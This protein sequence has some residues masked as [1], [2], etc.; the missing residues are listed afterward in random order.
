MAGAGAAG[1]LFHKD[2]A[3][4]P[5]QPQSA[6]PAETRGRARISIRVDFRR[7]ADPARCDELSAF[8]R[9]YRDVI[10]EIAF[11]T[12]FTHP[13]CPLADIQSRAAVLAG[14]LPRF[15]DLGLSAGINHIAMIG[16]LEENL[17]HSLGEP[18]QHLVDFD[19]TVSAACYCTADP[20]MRDYVRSCFTALAKAKP[21]FIW[22]DDDVRLEA[23]GRIRFACFCDRCLAAFSAQ[24]GKPWRRETLVAALQSGARVERLALRR[25]WL[26]HNRAYIKELMATVREAVD[27][28]DPAISLGLMTGETA[29]SG[30]GS[31]D[32]APVLAGE[33][34]RPVK[35]RP[36]GGFYNDDTPIQLLGKAHAV[37]RQIA[38]VP[39]SVGDIQY[40]LENF[41]YQRLKKSAAIFTTEIATAIAAGCTGAAL[42]C[43]GL[44][45]EPVAE[46]QAYFDGV[47]ARRAFYDKAVAAF[48]RSPSEGIWTAFT[49][50]HFATFQADGDWFA[51]PKVRGSDLQYINE[52][53]EIGLPLAY[54]RQGSRL[55][56]LSGDGCLDFTKAEL[57]ELLSRGLLLD[58][59]ALARLYELGLGE[60]AGFAVR[61]MKE[62]DT[63]E[64]FTDDVL[65]GRFAGR[66]R[67]CRPSFYPEPAWLIEP[68]SPA[69]RVLAEI[70]D[71]APASFGPTSGVF[72]NRLG[73]R[74]AVF[75][76]YPWRSLQS[77]AKTSQLKAVCRWLS[78]DTLPACVTSYAK[79]AV[80]CRRDPRGRQA[81]LLLNASLD[82]LPSVDLILQDAGP[83]E[84]TR[85]GGQTEELR[86]TGMDGP[87]T[88][89]ATP[90]VGP[91]E[92][93]LLTGP[94]KRY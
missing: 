12:G 47:R 1:L 64:R 77:P 72:E 44:A 17:E 82:P 8:V 3:A 11:F 36:G 46:Y 85:A 33:R 58:G 87:Y 55:A 7:G 40:E 54:S 28:V 50:D 62:K 56:A 23:H 65:N 66:C 9:H 37:G 27:S 6:M 19:G 75:G 53:A 41:P 4:D 30:Y 15:R 45:E 39:A 51:P 38:M 52:L 63:I 70:I 93:V 20:R 74:V 48:G 49:R 10:D 32:F 61:G 26:A 90:N 92:T 24:T 2:A 80:W 94:W 42:N 88:R 67:D 18:W 83:L 73:G 29:Y 31:A 25:Q 57:L 21:D 35:W 13:P 84:L 71:F 69:A 79:V 16:H 5:T 14:V 59:A 22:C 91:W 43:L 89:F 34:Q 81:I 86:M 60:H 78:R 68:R 76:Y